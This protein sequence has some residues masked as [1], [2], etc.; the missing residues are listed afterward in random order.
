MNPNP[1]EAVTNSSNSQDSFV[2]P[3]VRAVLELIDDAMQ[4]PSSQLKGE[5]EIAESRLVE[6]RD[7][8]IK[9]LRQAENRPAAQSHAL[10]TM[11][12]ALS[13]VV[14]IEYPA[15]GIHREALAEARDLLT[16]FLAD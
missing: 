12:I 11:N 8:L 9:T 3:R 7:H 10:E 4:R 5:V 1:A 14:S 15:A 6:L 2:L 16:R 13:L